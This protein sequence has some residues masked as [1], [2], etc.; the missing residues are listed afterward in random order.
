MRK[1]AREKYPTSRGGIDWQGMG[2]KNG[3]GRQTLRNYINYDLNDSNGLPKLGTAR[4]IALALDVEMN[5]IFDDADISDSN[6]GIEAGNAINQDQSE[7]LKKYNEEHRDEMREYNKKYYEENL[8]KEKNRA[9]KWRQENPDKEKKRVKKW[10]QENPD[11]EKKRVK[12]WRQENPDK[13]K[14]SGKKYREEHK[15]EKRE[16]DKE[17]YQKNKSKSAAIGRLTDALNNVI[18]SRE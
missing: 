1:L 12:K 9:K 15:Y 10:R 16:Y 4:L 11:K 5:E 7:Y 13:V 18:Q 6:G 14:E 8:D 17:R 3:I 2:K